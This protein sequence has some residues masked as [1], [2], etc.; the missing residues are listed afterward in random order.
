MRIVVQRLFRLLPGGGLCNWKLRF[1]AG[2]LPV[3]GLLKIPTKNQ[4]NKNKAYVT[5]VTLVNGTELLV[6]P[7]ARLGVPKPAPTL[8]RTEDAPI[9]PLRLENEL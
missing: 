9:K 7:V 2:R 5:T 3:A 6:V 1:S 4:T 8:P